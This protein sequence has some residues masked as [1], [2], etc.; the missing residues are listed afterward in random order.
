MHTH[1]HVCAKLLTSVLADEQCSLSVM[2]HAHLPRPVLL[3]PLLIAHAP[4]LTLLPSQQQR[5]EG[6][7]V[8]LPLLLL[9]LLPLTAAAAAAAWSGG[10]VC[11]HPATAAGVKEA[12]HSRASAQQG[13]HCIHMCCKHW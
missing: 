5:A 2:P 9:L 13:R 8:W 3:L 1:T 6:P 11:I 4:V 12:A 7:A 10:A